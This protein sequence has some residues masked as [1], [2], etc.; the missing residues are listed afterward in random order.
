MVTI[1]K[2]LLVAVMIH[3]LLIVV[4]CDMSTAQGQRQNQPW[5]PPGRGC[6]WYVAPSGQRSNSGKELA[7]PL[8]LSEAAKRTQPG[9]IVCLLPGKYDL[10]APVYISKGGT[11]EAY[12]TYTSYDPTEPALLNWTSSAVMDIVQVNNNAAYIRLQ[13]LEFNANNVAGEGIKC[14]P[15]SHHIVVAGNTINNAGSA[16]IAS[17]QCDYL[18]IDGNKIHHT[19]YGAGNSSGISLNRSVWFDQAAGFH[20]VVVNNIVA[21]SFDKATLKEKKA[22]GLRWIVKAT[23]RRC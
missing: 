21:G 3:A 2:K 1:R 6:T 12:V 10:D 13:G 15:G 23:R 14:S 9:D 5:L 20:S 17:V 18:T 7:S 11:A 22:T 4:S 16:G 19:G 8:T